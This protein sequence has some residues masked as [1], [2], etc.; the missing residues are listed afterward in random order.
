MPQWR[1]EVER[2]AG[3]LEQFSYAK[4]PVDAAS[5]LAADM[6][7]ELAAQ[8]AT[9]SSGVTEGE[10]ECPE[11]G[12]HVDSHDEDG[13]LMFVVKHDG[14]AACPC[15]QGKAR[16]PAPGETEGQAGSGEPDEM[17]IALLEANEGLGEAQCRIAVAAGLPRASSA[18]VI[19][20]RVRELVQSDAATVLAGLVEEMTA[21]AEEWSV[22]P[23]SGGAV[24]GIRSAR[25]LV[26]DAQQRL[27][28]NGE[29]L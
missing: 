5:R 21:L 24:D 11:C 27:V 22:L 3:I 15:W 8:A 1:S 19:E 12:H 28:Q 23:N 20:Q 14:E 26:R 13:C 6:R 16:S 7:R 9:P 17:L 4:N 25:A 2:W 18:D 29:Q 10:A